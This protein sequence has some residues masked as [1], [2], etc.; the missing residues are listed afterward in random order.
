MEVLFNGEIYIKNGPEPF[1]LSEESH[2]IMHDL[3]YE[4]TKKNPSLGDLY[5]L[6]G[7]QWLQEYEGE[8]DYSGCDHFWISLVEP[9]QTT[10]VEQNNNG[11]IAVLKRSFPDKDTILKKYTPLVDFLDQAKYIGRY[12]KRTA[13]T[14]YN[15]ATDYF[16]EDQ[17]VFVLYATDHN[18]LV[19]VTFLGETT[20]CMISPSYLEDRNYTYYGKYNEDFIDKKQISREIMNQILENVKQKQI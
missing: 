11:N 9:F 14:A 12:F 2:D 3:E 7:Y 4:S 19:R 10:M 1:Y 16:N 20:Y 17:S 18:M 8:R 6:E 5:L 13:P 15:G